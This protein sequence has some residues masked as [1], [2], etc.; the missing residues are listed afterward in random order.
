M[1]AYSDVLQPLEDITAGRE[2][3]EIISWSDSLLAAFKRSQDHLKNSKALTIP[4]PEDQLQVI[5]DASKTGIAAALYVIRGGKPWIAGHLSA[6]YKK[7]QHSWLPC[8]H[9]ALSICAA[10]TH[11]GPEIINSQKQTIILTDSLPCVQAYDKLGR[12]LFSSS[13]RVATFLSA[14]SRYNVHLM[15]LKGSENMYSDYAS[16]NPAECL[17]KKCEICKFITETSESVVRSCTVK[18]VLESTTPVPY[19]SRSGWHELQCSDDSMRRACAHLRQGTSPSKKD[20]HIKDV[21]RYL[22]KAR[23]AKDGLLVVIQYT[24]VAGRSEKIV[25]PRS[26][27]HGLLECL[28][29]KLN[30]PSK[31]QLRQ[32][33]TRAYYA[34]NLDDALDA[35]SKGCHTCISL[36][37]MP[38]RFLQQTTTTTPTAVGSNFSAD[39]IKRSGQLLL[40]ARE[41]VSSYTVGRIIK[42][43]KATTLRTALLILC[44]AVTSP[45]GPTTIIKVDPASSFR[46]LLDDAELKR[47]GL[48]LELGH[49]KYTNKNPVAERAIREIHS[50]IK[51]LLHESPEITEKILSQALANLNGRIR[52]EGV[53]SMEI[54][55]Q[56]N[57]FTG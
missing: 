34:L 31:A 1:Q 20:T 47:N 46:S 25:V 52:G 10:V 8:D 14:L 54:W 57:Q 18:D 29:L 43:E 9:E 51:R 13:A 41:Y 50:E 27:L 17:E 56:R 22:Q 35:V 21:K 5:T 26:Y 45:S 4:R 30:H 3:K 32:V 15:H 33:F 39:V 28:H 38:N 12:G 55:M 44:N 11:F 48:T 2:P 49:A 53:S 19:S 16:R 23:V 36:A 42:D 24:P 40:I 37:D 7:H 6:K